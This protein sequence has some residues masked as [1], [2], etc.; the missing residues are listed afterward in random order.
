M[1][2]SIACESSV[3]AICR[4]SGPRCR[5]RCH[6]LQH[7]SSE[8][9][10]ASRQHP[11]VSYSSCV[12]QATVARATSIRVLSQPLASRLRRRGAAAAP[13]PPAASA[14]GSRA[15][16]LSLCSPCLIT[17]PAGL[18]GWAGLV[19][20]CAGPLAPR[21]A[22]AHSGAGAA[23]RALQ[24]SCGAVPLVPRLHS[25]PTRLWH[26]HPPQRRSLA[27]LSARVSNRRAGSRGALAARPAPRQRW[28]LR[29]PPGP[30]AGERC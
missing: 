20:G 1:K 19:G 14:C 10:R 15:G 23:Q 30:G 24:P 3:C 2:R 25:T 12:A 27:H 8:E 29:P 6:R 16:R 5:R 13:P 9:A 17:Q 18:R 21:R 11:A 26:A 4:S 7:S 28:G 22:G